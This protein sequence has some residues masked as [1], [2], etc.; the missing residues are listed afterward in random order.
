MAKG[1]I[2]NAVIE[3]HVKRNVERVEAI[4]LGVLGP[5]GW[6][7]MAWK[8][9]TPFFIVVIIAGGWCEGGR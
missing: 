9:K 3:D 4:D 1:P 8:F 7:D 2:L 6:S 5:S